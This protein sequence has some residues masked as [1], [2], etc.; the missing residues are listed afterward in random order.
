MRNKR[1]NYLTISEVAQELKVSEITVYRWI[2]QKKLLYVKL[3]SGRIRIPS[4]EIERL[5]VESR[6][7]SNE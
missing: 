5:L 2:K 7:A 3:P 1:K 6:G 4:S